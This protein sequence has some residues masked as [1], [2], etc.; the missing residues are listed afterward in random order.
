MDKFK[1]DGY[2]QFSPGM[3]FIE[4][5]S[6]WLNQ[7][8]DL[9][10]RKIALDF[11]KKYL[12]YISGPEIDILVSSCYPDVIKPILLKKVGIALKIEQYH[13]SKISN[14]LKF[15]SLLRQSLFCGLSDGAR[16]ELFRRSNPG[17]LTHEQIYQTYELSEERAQKMQ[18]ELIADQ[19]KILEREPNLNERKFNY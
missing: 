6:L 17:I 2:Q 14:D 19:S 13:I 8:K 3:R 10:D 5:F 15:K 12:I 18:D 4:R 9:K 7:F 1:Y 16:V 11:V